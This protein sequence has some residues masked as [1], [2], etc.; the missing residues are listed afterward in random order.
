MPTAWTGRDWA[1]AVPWLV[2]ACRKVTQESLGFSP[3]DLVFAHTVLKDQLVCDSPV[4][5]I[6]SYV[7]RFRSRLQRAGELARESL[8][9][10]QGKM[11]RWYDLK[12]VD[13][14]FQ[15]GDRDL[16]LLPVPGSALQARFSGPYVV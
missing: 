6:L 9:Q 3:A 10:A 16:M 14:H 5:D 11:K 1:D 15:V 4:R 13:R 12:A 2:F 7:S 8:E